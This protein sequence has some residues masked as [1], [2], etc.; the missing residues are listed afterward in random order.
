MAIL[1]SIKNILAKHLNVKPSELWVNVWSMVG[2][3]TVNEIEC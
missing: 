2:R 1:L 3:E